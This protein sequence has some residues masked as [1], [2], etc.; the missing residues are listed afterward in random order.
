MALAV[1]RTATSPPAKKKAGRKRKRTIT[2]VQMSRKR[3]KR[4]PRPLEYDTKASVKLYN[5]L[6]FPKVRTDLRVLEGFA[7]KLP[8]DTR[9]T[10]NSYL[11]L[12]RLGL[13]KEWWVPESY[14]DAAWT[15]MILVQGCKDG[16]YTNGWG[17][18]DRLIKDMFEEYKWD[19]T[20]YRNQWRG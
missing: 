1:K 19:K 15:V 4:E 2:P 12:L 20:G 6:E 8:V 13:G 11:R 18:F 5:I 7:Q 17:H 3:H 14:M 9:R 16:T 10:Y